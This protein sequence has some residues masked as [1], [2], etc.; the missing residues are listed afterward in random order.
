VLGIWDEQ[1]LQQVLDDTPDVAPLLAS[2]A[3]EDLASLLR[4]PSFEPVDV[5]AQPRLDEKKAITCPECG[6]EFHP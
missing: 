2:L 5:D 3:G 6:A 4:G 1:G